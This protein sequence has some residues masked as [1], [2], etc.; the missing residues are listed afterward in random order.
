MRRII[1]LS[2]IITFL[3]FV[4]YSF[5]GFSIV[6]NRLNDYLIRHSK[7]ADTP[8]PIVIVAIDEY[9]RKDIPVWPWPTEVYN[10]LLQILRDNGAK[11]IAMDINLDLFSD[12]QDQKDIWTTEL[13]KAAGNVVLS[14]EI[15]QIKKHAMFTY[16]SNQLKSSVSVGVIRHYYDLDLYIRRT[17]LLTKVGG[18]I[19]PSFALGAATK[20]LGID[21]EQT[22]IVLA[23]RRLTLG[24]LAIPLDKENKMV[25]HYQL[26]PFPEIPFAKVLAPSFIKYN[27]KIF[28][29]KIVLVGV[30]ATDLVDNFAT[31]ISK[32]L[33]GPQLQAN[34]MNTLISRTFPKTLPHI[35]YLPLIL[36][37][38]LVAAYISLK[39][40]PVFNVLSFFVLGSFAPLIGFYGFH[41]GWII[42]ITAPC[43]ALMATYFVGILIRFLTGEKEKRDIRNLFNQYV[44]PSV[45][46]EL[47][48]NRKEYQIPMVKKDASVLF[49]DIRDFTA[50]SATH[51]PEVIIAQVNEFLNAMT[52]II[53]AHGGTIDKYIGD[54]IMAIWGSPLPQSDHAMR[55]VRSGID[56]LAKMEQLQEKWCREGKTILDVGIGICSGEVVAGTM[57]AEKHKEYTV[58]GNTVNLAAKIQDQT[59]QVSKERGSLCHFIISDSTHKLL[60]TE[61]ETVFLGEI[62]ISSGQIPLKIWEVKGL[63]R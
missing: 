28:A 5:E 29:G 3:V 7:T 20:Y 37:F 10:Q 45:V 25:I 6:D 62:M 2:A 35:S 38:S 13:A 11:V 27:P 56:Q 21:L 8:P 33:T 12:Y 44:S 17:D 53:T 14:Q 26:A 39:K 22:P 48:G 31:S 19:Y 43:V 23:N 30:T 51:E 18:R 63:K 40:S 47:L 49:I 60:E 57:G 50:Y 58:V 24:N 42:N 15:K 55:A 1:W 54:S 4:I 52:N 61:I 9:S 59:R 34:I 36:I 46:K 41:H 16:R 32:K